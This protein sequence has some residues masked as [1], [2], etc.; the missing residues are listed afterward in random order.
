MVTSVPSSL[1]KP[2][3]LRTP[4]L[5][6][7]PNVSFL[8]SCCGPPRE[9]QLRARTQSPQRAAHM[10]QDASVY[11]CVLATSKT[12]NMFQK[13]AKK[14]MNMNHIENATSSWTT[15]I[16]ATASIEFECWHTILW[17]LELLRRILGGSKVSHPRYP[18]SVGF[19]CVCHQQRTHCILAFD[20]RHLYVLF[21]GAI[22]IQGGWLALGP[23][24]L[25]KLGIDHVLAPF[26]V[27]MGPS[28]RSGG[29]KFRRGTGG[30]T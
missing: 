8:E 27:G 3:L 24:R 30:G 15:T 21:N 7:S 23:F 17:Q 13:A 16:A 19:S 22:T 14:M 28:G 6:S 25:S 29:S 1:L 26:S 11:N 12:E 5:M 20:H 9:F 2:C 18:R 10:T 4:D